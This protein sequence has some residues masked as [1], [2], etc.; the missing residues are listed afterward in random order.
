[1]GVEKVLVAKAAIIVLVAMWSPID[2]YIFTTPQFENKQECVEYVM[3][4]HIVLNE[5]LQKI[6]D[7]RFKNNEFFCVKSERLKR[8]LRETNK[9]AI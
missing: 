7:G 6:Y 8:V 4:N 3:V 5:H 2:F 9:P 1:M